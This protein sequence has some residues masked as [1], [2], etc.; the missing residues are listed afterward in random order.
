VHAAVRAADAEAC[1]AAHG[2]SPVGLLERAGALGPGTT[3]VHATALSGADLAALGEARATVCALP[4]TARH[5]GLGAVPADLL[6]AAGARVAL[7]AGDHAEVDLLGEARALELHLR[8]LRGVPAAL[9]D[10][11]GTLPGKLLQAASAA[12]MG[13]LGLAGGRLAPGDPADF[14]LLDADDPSLA[15]ADDPDALLASLALGSSP[16]AVK[17]TFV[18]GDPILEDGWTTPGRPSGASLLGDFRE[19]MAGIW[20]GA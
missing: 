9:D 7:G 20:G 1:R 3:L 5:A 14:V 4:L 11:P 8:L 15:G 10:P 2:A 6:L 19:A 12:G 13:A 18:A 16:A 17:S